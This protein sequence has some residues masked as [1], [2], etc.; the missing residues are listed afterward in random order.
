MF[1]P[2]RAFL[3]LLVLI[4]VF[5]ASL[6]PVY[7]AFTFDGV[8]LSDFPAPTAGYDYC[9]HV[10]N[11][12][13]DPNITDTELIWHTGF[14]ATTGTCPATPSATL[15][16]WSSST[17]NR[18][19]SY[20]GS[21]AML[22]HTW[23]GS[24][25]ITG[26][27]TS[28][29]RSIDTA[30]C[31]NSEDSLLFDL[32]LYAYDTYNWYALY[33][34]TLGN[35][36]AGALL[37]TP[38]MDFDAPPIA[39]SFSIDSVSVATASGTIDMSLSGAFSY[40]DVGE[41]DL[42]RLDLYNSSYVD[43]A[44]RSPSVPLGHIYMSGEWAGA[45]LRGEWPPNYTLLPPTVGPI[46][47]ADGNTRGWTADVSLKSFPGEPFTLS[48]KRTCFYSSVNDDLLINAYNSTGTSLSATG[49]G[50][51]VTPIA[52]ACSDFDSLS[53]VE[54]I[55]C[56]ITDGFN[57]VLKSLFVPNFD[58]VQ[59]SQVDTL[60]TL[61]NSK[62]PFAYFM[63]LADLDLVSSASAYPTFEVPLMPNA[64]P[65]V[66]YSWSIPSSLNSMVS[67]LSSFFMFSVWLS[68]LIYLISRGRRFFK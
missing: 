21:L 64:D 29:M 28:R 37:F 61:L 31:L 39:T 40:D 62:A 59:L 3:F 58:N 38:N 56:Q 35:K 54:K 46:F 57:Y 55:T 14:I 12:G 60:V 5:T 7:S 50:S 4:P 6:K 18:V 2:Y 47:L 26:S 27:N 66:V 24:T 11:Y 63:P 41:E 48:Y 67:A 17:P 16:R 8:T 42:C 68:F 49:S 33:C 25:W 22:F 45:T 51:L 1:S 23:D 44:G 30:R 20:S 34:S 52:S 15:R 65:P 53:A 32:P 10:V 19:Y 36:T 43:F 9:G 13:D